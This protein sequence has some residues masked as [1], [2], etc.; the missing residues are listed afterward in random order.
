MYYY[1][2]GG[3]EEAY[4]YLDN[5]SGF[6]HRFSRGHLFPFRLEG[7]GNVATDYQLGNESGRYYG[8]IPHVRYTSNPWSGVSEDTIKV[9]FNGVPTTFR[10]F[11]D[12]LSS[13]WRAMG[14]EIA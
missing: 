8:I 6:D 10:L 12:E 11:Y 14:P 2:V 1:N 7:P 13:Q 4:Y 3:E 9:M 5:G